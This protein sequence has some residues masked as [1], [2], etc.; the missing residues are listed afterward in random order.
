MRSCGVR[1]SVLMSVAV[2]SMFRLRP[3]RR[4]AVAILLTVSL[5]AGGGV[6]AMARTALASGLAMPRANR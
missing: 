1:K 3:T 4:S 5:A 2:C 6:G